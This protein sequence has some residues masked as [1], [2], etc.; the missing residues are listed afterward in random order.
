MKNSLVSVSAALFVNTL[1]VC[2]A[3]ATMVSSFEP[4]FTAPGVWFEDDTR[5]NGTTGVVDL[6]GAGGN[7]EN[8]A[9]LGNSA[10]KL[11]TGMANNDKAQVTVYDNFGT[12]EDFLASGTLAYDF[13]KALVPGGNIHAAAAIKLLVQDFNTTASDSFGA[14][15]YEPYIN[16][17]G[18]PVT[19]DEWAT[20]NITGTS[21]KFWSTG[22]Y[23][24]ANQAGGPGQ[25]MMD[26]FAQFGTD[27]LD[28]NIIGISVG[29]GS[30]N[31]GQEAYFDN[32][33]FA[34]GNIRAAYDFEL[35]TSTVPVPAALPLL[36]T[37]LALMGFVGWRRKHQ[38]A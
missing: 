15:V 26:W 10:A 18:A 7:L 14:F 5:D 11:T 27:F 30:Y 32:I 6:T 21:G 36:G 24:Q 2:G 17:G 28:A 31:Q 23:G 16:D 8:N 25:T 13:Y 37:G 35:E 12:M 20:E 19:T 1:L 4:N 33:L 3:N 29:V 38:Q 22:I 9:P 34:S